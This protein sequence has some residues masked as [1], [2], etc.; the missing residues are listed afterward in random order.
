MVK[1]GNIFSI[2]KGLNFNS[3]NVLYS[4]KLIKYKNISLIKYNRRNRLK[5]QFCY[6]IENFSIK[7]GQPNFPPYS[8]WRLMS[9]SFSGNR[10]VKSSLVSGIVKVAL[11][12]R[13]TMVS[14]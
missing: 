9:T 3:F 12:F 4:I 14:P 7:H 2:I 1:S 5:I 11:D 13:N 6:N 8:V 10:K